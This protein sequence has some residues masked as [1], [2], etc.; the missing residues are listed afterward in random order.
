MI[1]IKKSASIY[2]GGL[3]FGL[4]FSILASIIYPSL[5]TSILAF[6]VQKVETQTTVMPNITMMI[7]VNN[8]VASGFGAFGGVVLSNLA[9]IFSLRASRNFSLLISIP[10][11]VLFVNGFVLG[12]LGFLYITD[13]M[14]FLKGILPHGFFEIPALIIAGSIGLKFAESKSFQESPSKYHIKEMIKDFL[15]VVILVVVA[16]ILE[17]LKF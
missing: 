17:G 1:H 12:F 10:G 13:I 9:S 6:L 2:F 14:G 16:G 15:P 8:L 7:I 11:G 3:V 4:A 5:L